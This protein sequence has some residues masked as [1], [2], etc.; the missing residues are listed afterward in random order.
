MVIEAMPETVI[1]VELE[2]Q[3]ELILVF[4]SPETC[5]TSKLVKQNFYNN[6]DYRYL[7]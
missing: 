2:L 5:A 6:R 7:G 4:D 3:L 1:Y